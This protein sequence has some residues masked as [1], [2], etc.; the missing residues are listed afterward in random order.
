[1]S[2]KKKPENHM[3]LPRHR[4][5]TYVHKGAAIYDTLRLLEDLEGGKI[6]RESGAVDP[7][8]ILGWTNLDH[9]YN[10]DVIKA[11]VNE[12]LSTHSP[13]QR[14]SP[15]VLVECPGESPWV[16]LGHDHLQVA[17]LTG[18]CGIDVHVIQHQSM[19]PYRVA[20]PALAPK[21]FENLGPYLVAHFDEVKNEFKHPDHS[22]DTHKLDHAYVL[23]ILQLKQFFEVN[24]ETDADAWTRIANFNRGPDN[25]YHVPLEWSFN[26]FDDKFKEIR[27]ITVEHLDIRG[28][29]KAL[30]SEYKIPKQ[31]RLKINKKYDKNSMDHSY[32]FLRGIYA[33]ARLLHAAYHQSLDMQRFSRF[34]GERI[35]ADPVFKTQKDFIEKVALG[36][37]TANDEPITIH[38]LAQIAFLSRVNPADIWWSVQYKRD[39]LELACVLS[40]LSNDQGAL[41]TPAIAQAAADIWHRAAAAEDRQERDADDDAA[42]MLRDLL[43]ELCDISDFDAVAKKVVETRQPT[44]LKVA[45]TEDVSGVVP[46]PLFQSRL[47]GR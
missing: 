5:W 19:S 4:D 33:N 36:R 2:G 41:L 46:Y 45:K 34:A 6:P 43:C 11:V 9:E 38:G 10:W 32:I 20:M 21:E 16:V 24:G 44:F 31:K 22:E 17:R 27:S 39:E 42:V 30:R 37:P 3:S 28:I 26:T 7:R 1:M 15:I 47:I 14:L 8:Q 25:R 40:Q 23:Q 12:N 35:Q 29:K 13:T 18:V